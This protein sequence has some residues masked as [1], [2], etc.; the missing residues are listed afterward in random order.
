MLLCELNDFINLVGRG[1]G[2]CSLN[3]SVKVVDEIA[4]LDELKLFLVKVECLGLF[5]L[6]LWKVACD[7]FTALYDRLINAKEQLFDLGVPDIPDDLDFFAAK[8]DE[9]RQVRR[10]LAECGVG[11]VHAIIYL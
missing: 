4:Q 11:Q 6:V 5:K 2:S 9:G 7:L 10:H 8:V 1:T 3:H